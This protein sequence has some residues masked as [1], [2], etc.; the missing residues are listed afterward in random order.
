[1]RIVT[2]N[3]HGECRPE[4]VL[5]L[6]YEA[7]R[8]GRTAAGHYI[9]PGQSLADVALGLSHAIPTH[10]CQGLFQAKADGAV[11]TL[12]AVDAADDVKFG[13]YCETVVDGDF[14]RRAPGGKT[15]V[16]ITE[17]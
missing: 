11:I 8:G 10:F 15:L 12:V 1:M 9:R 5:V 7:K 2:F 14:A 4:D 3:L 17:R 16:E 13:W 6:Y